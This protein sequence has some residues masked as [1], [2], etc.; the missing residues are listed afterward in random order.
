M[1]IAAMEAEHDEYVE[2]ELAMEA[3]EEAYVQAY[4]DSFSPAPHT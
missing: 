2:H 4:V 1:E 3:W